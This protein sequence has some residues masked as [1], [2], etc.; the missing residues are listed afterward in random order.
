MCVNA[1][2]CMCIGSEGEEI[3]QNLKKSYHVSKAL[4]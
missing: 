3:M 1:S 2:V 4:R